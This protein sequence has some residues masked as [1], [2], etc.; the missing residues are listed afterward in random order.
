MVYVWFFHIYFFLLSNCTVRFM[1]PCVLNINKKIEEILKRKN[2]ARRHSYTHSQWINQFDYK[3]LCVKHG[4][5]VLTLSSLKF[6]TEYISE[7]NCSSVFQNSF[8]GFQKKTLRV[9]LANTHEQIKRFLII[10]Y[11]FLSFSSIET[12]ISFTQ[13]LLCCYFLHFKRIETQINNFMFREKSSPF[14]NYKNL[15]RLKS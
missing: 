15:M 3:N 13:E 4:K 9:N 1:L 8:C 2:M 10:L 5:S 7:I 14:W 11:I 6:V 12:D